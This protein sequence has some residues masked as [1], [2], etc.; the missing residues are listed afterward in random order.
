M[1]EEDFKGIIMPAIRQYHKS[2]GRKWCI[3]MGNE[4]W[5]DP[6]AHKELQSMVAARIPIVYETNVMD[7]LTG[8]VTSTKIPEGP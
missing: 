6:V 4:I 8:E 3:F 1:T 2:R 7:E 5:L